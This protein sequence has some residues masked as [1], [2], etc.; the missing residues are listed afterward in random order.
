MNFDQTTPIYFISLLAGMR[1][2]P[3]FHLNSEHSLFIS[4]VALR[5]AS[6][7]RF[8]EELVGGRR[9]TLIILDPLDVV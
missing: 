1:D 9:S 8:L 5:A 7:F 3:T 2:G 6:R 4:L